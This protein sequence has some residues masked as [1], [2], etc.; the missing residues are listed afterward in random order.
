MTLGLTGGYCA[1]KSSAAA[2]L[3]EAGWTVIDVDSLGHAALERSAAEV[4]R[5]LGPGSLK[6]DGGPDRRAIGAMVFADPALLARYEAVVHPAMNALVEEAV[7][8]AGPKACVDA[9]ILYRLPIA[10][11]CD[12]I[13]EV[14]APLALRL[15]RGRARDGLGSLAIL[16]RIRSQKPLRAAGS[17][18]EGKTVVVS[19][20]WGAGVF[21]RRVVELA[22]RAYRSLN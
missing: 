2:A 17:A 12:T 5:L 4:A 10:A 22:E 9:A 8:R 21:K 7:S 14:R 6:A 20:A 1:G 15:L 13:I 19:N 3:R 16:R 11:A 18:W